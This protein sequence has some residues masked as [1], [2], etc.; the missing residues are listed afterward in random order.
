[1]VEKA[2]LLDSLKN[3]LRIV[4]NESAERYHQ[5]QLELDETKM[6]LMAYQMQMNIE[7]DNFDVI[8]TEFHDEKED[9]N[10]ENAE[11]IA[12]K[13]I[14]EKKIEMMSGINKELSS[15]IELLDNKK[16]ERNGFDSVLESKGSDSI[17]SSWKQ[18]KTD[19]SIKE[20]N[21]K[22]TDES[23]KNNVVSPNR[24]N[25]QSK[26]KF[27][28]QNEDD[29]EE[30]FEAIQGDSGKADRDLFVPKF[31]RPHSKCKVI[32]FFVNKK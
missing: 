23:S 2:T 1:M 18:I 13:K 14:L 12:K 5:L 10:K 15:Q 16:S 29:E 22:D 8:L 19:G 26:N 25:Q 31:V 28:F 17:S 27:D 6:S 3:Q 21:F 7:R 24:K 9:I 30:V 4:K 11:L 32:F 20:T